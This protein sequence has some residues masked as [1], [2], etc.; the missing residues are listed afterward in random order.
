MNWDIVG[1]SV[2]DMVKN[3]FRGGCLDLNLNRTMLVFILKTQRVET[4][5]HL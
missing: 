1:G 5:N 4:M 2:H 3:V